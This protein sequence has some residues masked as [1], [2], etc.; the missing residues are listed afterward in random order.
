MSAVGYEVTLKRSAGGP[1]IGRSRHCDCACR[2][3]GRSEAYLCIF[4]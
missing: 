2:D 1:L 4:G 3:Q